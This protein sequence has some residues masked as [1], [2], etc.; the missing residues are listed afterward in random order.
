MQLLA[1]ISIL[2]FGIIIGGV[3][4]A[5]AGVGIGIPMIPIGIYLTYRGWRIFRHEADAKKSEPDDEKELVSFEKTKLGKFG[6]GF[7]LILI[8][9]GTSSI[10]IG[11]LIFF[12]GVWLVYRAYRTP[13]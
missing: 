4:L 7:I 5:T 9:I 3:G 12:V 2:L 6:L 13:H 10:G 8:G 11:M 1:G